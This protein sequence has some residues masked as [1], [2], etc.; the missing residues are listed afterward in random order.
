M[1]VG[2]FLVDLSVRHRVGDR[3]V[4]CVLEIFGFLNYD[5]FFLFL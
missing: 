2:F 1:R 3:S 4:F 5:D